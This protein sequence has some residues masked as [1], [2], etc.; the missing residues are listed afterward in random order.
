MICV[1]TSATQPN[2]GGAAVTACKYLEALKT[3]MVTQRS[4]V[5][6][7]MDP[8]PEKASILLFSRDHF[9]WLFLL[10]CLFVLNWGL[11]S[12]RSVYICYTFPFHSVIDATFCIFSTH[13]S[14]PGGS[15]SF[16]KPVF[17]KS[18]WCRWVM[19][20]MG[21]LPPTTSLFLLITHIQMC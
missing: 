3:Q 18:T 13:I 12:H 7:D 5:L 21:D 1:V 15:V 8:S 14:H 20:A 19:K 9:C 16:A 17:S 6:G 2:L 11:I 4:D 10:S